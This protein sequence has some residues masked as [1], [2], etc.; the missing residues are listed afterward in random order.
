ME[1]QK[2]SDCTRAV[3][4]LDICEYVMHHILSN[5]SRGKAMSIFA[6]VNDAKLELRFYGNSGYAAIKGIGAAYEILD[7]SR[8]LKFPTTRQLRSLAKKYL[9]SPLSEFFRCEDTKQTG[10]LF[11]G[12][13][14]GTTLE[15]RAVFLAA[16]AAHSRP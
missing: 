14:G 9:N 11:L 15:R 1:H 7:A 2:D 5:K 10:V 8:R 16:V 12:F 3:S 13:K 4:N 6:E